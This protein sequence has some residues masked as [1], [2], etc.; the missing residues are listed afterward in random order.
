VN[1]NG[2]QLLPVNFNI[3]SGIKGTVRQDLRRANSGIG[4]SLTL[5]Q[6]GS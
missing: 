2:C 5:F 6:L 4:L 3:H 1:E